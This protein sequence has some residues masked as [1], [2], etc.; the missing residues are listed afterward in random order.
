MFCGNCGRQIPNEAV[1]CPGCGA[2][3][4]NGAVSVPS[5]DIQAKKT[6]DAKHRFIGIGAVA[7]AA[8]VLI[9]VCVVIFGGR[10]YKSVVNQYIT[11]AFEGDG[12]AVMALLPDGMFDAL[13]EESGMTAKEYY[14]EINDDLASMVNQLD[15]YYGDWTYSYEITGAMD[16][17]D[18]IA[19]EA[20]SREEAEEMME[21]V[22]EIKEYFK[23]YF[24]LTVKAIKGVTV[25]I[26][27]VG[28]EMEVTNSVGILVVKLG[29]SWYLL[30][31]GEELF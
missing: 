16:A 24:G 6:A 19:E 1:F 5:Y 4:N 20:E 30:A 29:R 2:K 7:A 15:R 11:A 22:E 31:P 26:T 27:V 10:S 17:S 8:I 12:E 18:W 21:E 14:A 13:V 28:D 9:V 3:V 25:D 23:E